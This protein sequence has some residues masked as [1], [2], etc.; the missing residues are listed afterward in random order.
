MNTAPFRSLVALTAL[1]V[2]PSQADGDSLPSWK[3]ASAR[4][5]IVKFVEEVT[6]PGSP[7]Y[8]KPADR[9]AVF[10][11]DGT[12]WTELPTYPQFYFG[13]ARVKAN[14]SRH[15][16]WSAV[17]PF[18]SALAGDLEGVVASGVRGLIELTAAPH[19]GL[20]PDEFEQVATAWLSQAR[21]PRFGRPYT[22][23]V[24][25][26]ML[27]LL[28][29]LQA[30]EF[31]TYIVSGGSQEFLRPWTAHVYGIPASRVIG[32]TVVTR[33]ERR[34][35]K[36]VIVRTGKIELVNDKEEKVLSIQR[37]IGQRPILAF[38]N[39][40]G[41]LPMLEWTAGGA[42]L[43]F[44]GYVHHT[45]AEREYAYDRQSKTGRLDKGLDTA[46]AK[47]WT[48]VDIKQDW[49]RVFNFEPGPR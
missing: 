25:L 41:D 43:R 11:N 39:S 47:G 36:P 6:T 40:D 4:N 9:V 2:L 34:D 22:E 46:R 13:M 38:G 20:T 18:K 17:E 28:R 29:W 44:C 1:S 5:S 14:A 37:V 26:P 30:K 27:E 3:D 10:D 12:L 33:W 7:H 42:G 8:V 32:S 16:E 21:H 31:Q 24:Y 45:D 19:D 23:C 15:P 35:G 49:H 48:V